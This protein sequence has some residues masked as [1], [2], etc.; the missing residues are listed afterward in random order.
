MI[1]GVDM[2]TLKATILALALGCAGPA[3]AGLKICND[4]G[5]EQS[6]AIGH[7]VDG[8]WTS[9]GW[10]NIEDGGCSDTVAGDLQNR[11]YYYRAEVPDGDF[12]DEGYVFCVID[13]VFTIEGQDGCEARGYEEAGFRRIDTGPTA[14]EFTLTLVAPED[15][16]PDDKR[17]T[18][19]PTTNTSLRKSPEPD[20]GDEAR[21]PRRDTI[22]PDTWTSGYRQGSSGDP[23]SQVAMFQGCDSFDGTRYCA[24]HAEGWKWYAY[25]DGPTPDFFLDQVSNLVRG[26]GVE[27]EG[28]ILSMGDISVEVALSALTV[29]PAS[30]EHEREFNLIQ[31]GW[32]SVDDP[33][34]LWEFVGG[35]LY[36]TYANDPPDV[37]FWRFASG[38]DD[39][40]PDVDFVMIKTLPETQEQQC[41]VPMVVSLETLELVYA[42]RGNTL[43]FRR[44]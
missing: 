15:Y 29:R 24:F 17:K 10:W 11:Y 27:I 14:T 35:E 33:N 2:N 39:A 6:V 4:T 5:Q 38:C 36:E 16:A 37:F 34:N 25:Y 18:P 31:G 23:F 19:E 1:L 26:V 43:S 32:L 9:E 21:L 20:G 12:E 44:P 7:L 42:P 40:P 13:D 22:G 30:I 3:M 41:Y 28:D 8:S